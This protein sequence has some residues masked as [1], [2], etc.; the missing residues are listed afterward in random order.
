MLIS[1][2][3]TLILYA[4][5]IFG[6]RIMGKR[7]VGQLQPSELV[8]T[9]LISNIATLPIENSDVP[10][11]LGAVPIITL[12]CFDVLVSMLSLKS[13]RFRHLVAGNPRIL[14]QNGIIDQ[15]EL[16]NLRFSIDDLMEELRTNDIFDL[17]EVELAIVETTG[18]LSVCKKSQHETLT[19]KTANIHIENTPPP[20]VVISD[21]KIIDDGLTLC[22]I[23]A[24]TL[25]ELL[26]KEGYRPEDIFLMTCTSDGDYYI[27]PISKA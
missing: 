4:I 25:K 1:F 23:S 2:L 22:G 26:K 18:H 5:V 12:I 11:V 3:R 7:Q 14:I 15:K 6:M 27:V 19:P 24:H 8:I 17:R 20:F 16:A 21:R 9:I 10:L 13:I